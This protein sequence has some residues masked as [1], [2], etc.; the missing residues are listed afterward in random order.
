MDIPQPEIPGSAEGLQMRVPYVASHK[1]RATG[2]RDSAPDEAGSVK[3]C[4]TLDEAYELTRLSYPKGWRMPPTDE[5]DQQ[6]ALEAK[7]DACREYDEM[8]G[9]HNGAYEP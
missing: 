5:I 7:E 4:L 3:P 8:G 9:P 1:A 2:C 6:R